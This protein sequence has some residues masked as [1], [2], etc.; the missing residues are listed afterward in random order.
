MERKLTDLCPFPDKPGWTM[1]DCFTA[2]RCACA[3]GVRLGYKPTTMPLK[4]LVRPA[5]AEWH[6]DEHGNLS[7]AHS[8]T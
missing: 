7:R 6:K 3:D 8:R 4:P 5:E 1:H 2:K